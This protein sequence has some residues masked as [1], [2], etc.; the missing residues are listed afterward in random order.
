MT[1]A[2]FT[3]TIIGAGIGGLTAALAL[4][5]A[6]FDVAVY[7]QAPEL[8]EV[9]GGIN[10]GPDA[11]VLAACFV[12]DGAHDPV[13]TLRRYERL[14]CPRVTRLQTM[15]R[16]N[17]TRFHL[18]AGPAQEARDAEWARAGDRSPESLRWL[19]GFDA[20]SLSEP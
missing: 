19:Y 16:A 14:R 17:R 10:M 13:E 20:G 6:G 18:P 11:A 15:S 3:I 7:E 4:R 12:A 5:Q 1:R 9:G 8:T 2:P